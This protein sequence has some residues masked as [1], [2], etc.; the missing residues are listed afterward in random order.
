MKTTKR[1]VFVN[2]V[3]MYKIYIYYEKSVF[4]FQIIYMRQFRDLRSFCIKGNPCC[5]DEL[6]YDFFMSGLPKIRYLDYKC[7][8]DNDREKGRS[9]FRYLLLLGI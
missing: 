6:A 2:F 4:T 7:I 3:K 1:F 8:H 5:D 9:I